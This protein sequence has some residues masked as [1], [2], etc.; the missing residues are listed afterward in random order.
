MKSY[1]FYE[2]WKPKI[3]NRC[4]KSDWRVSGRDEYDKM[5]FPMKLLKNRDKSDETRSEYY[6]HKAVRFHG[7]KMSS[8][9]LAKVGN[10]DVESGEDGYHMRTL[11]CVHT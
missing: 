6:D 11:E 5:S 9:R 3:I 7:Q 4:L 10:T 1:K 8:R 2:P